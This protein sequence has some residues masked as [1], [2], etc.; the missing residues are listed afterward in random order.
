MFSVRPGCSAVDGGGGVDGGVDAQRS[1]GTAPV[2]PRAP[3]VGRV[4]PLEAAQEPLPAQSSKEVQPP[5]TLPP[6]RPAAIKPNDLNF[7]G[8]G[9]VGRVERIKKLGVF[10]VDLFR[11]VNW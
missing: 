3:G 8:I 2:P 7:C 11:A 6:I 10:L 5:L 9:A 4:R 1:A